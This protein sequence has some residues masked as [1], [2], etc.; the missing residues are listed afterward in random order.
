MNQDLL[1]DDL[2][3][4]PPP[5]IPEFIDES[6]TR[7][8]MKGGPP[9]PPHLHSHLH[10]FLLQVGRGDDGRDDRRE[11]DQAGADARRAAVQEPARADRPLHDDGGARRQHEGHSRG[12]DGAEDGA[13]G[14][15][16]ED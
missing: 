14:A 16:R 15:S 3:D 13:V 9:P 8:K 1:F 10:C 11:Q 5:P 4:T 2:P 7:P 12:L 6:S